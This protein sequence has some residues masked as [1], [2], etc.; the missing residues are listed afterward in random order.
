MSDHP[1]VTVIVPAFNAA[2][3]IEASLNSLIGQSL[4]SWEAIVVDDA[5]TDSTVDLVAAMAAHDDRIRLVQLEQNAGPAAA[6]NRGLEQARGDWIAVLDGDDLMVPDRLLCLTGRAAEVG[7]DIISDNLV[8]FEDGDPSTAAPYLAP[9][10]SGWL[11]AERY[12]AQG[13]LLDDKPDLGYLKPLFRAKVFR[14]HELR[15]DERLRIAEDD[16]L[17]LRALLAGLCYW[18]EYGEGYIYRRHVGSISYRLLPT[19]ALSMF[20]VSDER[21]ARLESATHRRAL[22]LRHEA[23][24]RGLGFV[25]LVEALKAQHFRRIAEIVLKY[26]TSLPLLRLPI[27]AAFRRLVPASPPAVRHPALEQLVRE[28]LKA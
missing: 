6:R 3:F 1:L 21:L 28:T 19:H 9:G 15:Y 10:R 5:S 16:D 23:I 27:G 11:T 7:A 17:V 2:Q 14:D 25:L 22:Q 13:A 12:L 4:G 20:K 18:L 8:S 26:P 24:R